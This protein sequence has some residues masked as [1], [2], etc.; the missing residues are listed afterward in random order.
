[1]CPVSTGGGSRCVQLIREG[2]GG[3]YTFWPVLRRPGSRK[4]L[5]RRAGRGVTRWAG[6]FELYGYDIMIDDELKPWLLEVNASP[7]L[8]ADTASD[9]EVRVGRGRPLLCRTL[10]PRTLL[11]LPTSNASDALPVSIR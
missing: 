2:G 11:P 8:T 9:H 3:G 7:S 6:S 4:R 10:L 1:V 5:R